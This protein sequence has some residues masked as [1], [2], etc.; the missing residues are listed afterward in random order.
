MKKIAATFIDA[1][2]KDKNSKWLLLIVIISYGV[3]LVYNLHVAPLNME[4]PRRGIVA[5]EMLFNNNFIVTTLL[6]DTFYDHPPLWNI[7]LAMSI[8]VFGFNAFA[9]RFPAALAFLLTGILLYF[10]GKKHVN[11]TFGIFSALYYLI[12]VDLYFFFATAAEIDIFYSLLVLLALL[13]I[14]H[15]YQTKQFYWLFGCT[16]F[17][18]NLAFLTKGFSTY[19]FIG[20]TLLAYFIYTKSFKKLFS[21]PHILFGILSIG[22]IALYFYVYNLYEDTETYITKMWRLTTDKTASESIKNF[23]IH[24][25][26]YPM[27]IIGNIFPSTIFLL[28]LWDKK[29]IQRIKEQPYIL[30]LAITVLANIWI[31]SVSS[32]AR[33]RYSYMFFPMIISILVYAFSQ[34][35][36]EKSWKHTLYYT[37]LLCVF[38]IITIACFATPFVSLLSVIEGLNYKMPLI[39]CAALATIFFTLKTNGWTKHLFIILFFI[40][41]RYAYNTAALPMRNVK[42]SSAAFRI[43]ANAIYKEAKNN[44]IYVLSDEEMGSFKYYNVKFYSVIAYLEMYREGL[45]I[46]TPTLENS[47]YYIINRKDLKQHSSLYD[48]NIKG[49]NFSLIK[50]P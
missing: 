29:I 47:G 32:G 3:S 5:M 8:K 11:K 35:I 44:P 16:Y 31:F 17:F 23:L 21:V 41:T 48:F 50:V 12:S 30:F 42:S 13:S 49:L 45:V 4:E 24:F 26:T 2:Q 40:I 1:L 18:A 10:V 36:M 27:E 6:N 25:I 38:G 43:Q 28:F 15:F 33:I 14:F 19:G 20:L 9:L 39:G 46:K 22:F 7:I 34:K 37:L